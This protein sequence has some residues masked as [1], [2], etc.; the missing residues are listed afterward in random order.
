MGYKPGARAARAAV[1]GRAAPG[2]A[3][4]RAG[5]GAARARGG[6]AWRGCGAAGLRPLQRP[7][8]SGSSRSAA[9]TSCSLRGVAVSQ[10]GG[11]GEAGGRAGKDL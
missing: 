3:A 4:R 10:N 1:A 6:A 5:P 2:G 9:S 11:A 8:S 7:L